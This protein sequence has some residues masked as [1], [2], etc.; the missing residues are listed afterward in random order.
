MDKVNE[1]K[2]EPGNFVLRMEEFSKKLE[3]T[4]SWHDEAKMGNYYAEFR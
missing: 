3:E 4:D 1:K 2:Q